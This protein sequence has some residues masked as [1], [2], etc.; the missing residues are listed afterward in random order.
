MAA[1]IPSGAPHNRDEEFA[2]FM[3]GEGELPAG[4]P[5]NRMEE[6]MMWLAENGGW[7][8]ESNVFVF[9]GTVTYDYDAEQYVFT[10]DTPPADVIEQARNGKFIV[11]NASGEVY[12]Q[13]ASYNNDTYFTVA[14]RSL[15]NALNSN[16]L[17]LR[18]SVIQGTPMYSIDV[19][20]GARQ[21]PPANNANVGDALLVI[22]PN[23]YDWHPVET[24]I[25]DPI[26][27]GAF[28]TQFDQ[29]VYAAKAAAES[30]ADGFYGFTIPNNNAD[31]IS[32][33]FGYINAGKMVSL[34]VSLENNDYDI[35]ALESA[36]VND[37]TFSFVGTHAVTDGQTYTTDR[38]SLRF[39]FTSSAI[40]IE[41]QYKAL[42]VLNV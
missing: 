31:L 38:Y 18:V 25:R 16:I 13:T 23:S 17:V 3:G 4:A 5:E 19:I 36:Q 14:L 30:A 41:C 21:V 33:V 35:Y 28:K 6:W 40:A 12:T 10:S 15:E 22:G 1:E 29:L 20:E 27:S 42:P 2:L 37:N 9:D 8:G 32:E 26:L 39:T 7:G 34:A 24:I 11:C